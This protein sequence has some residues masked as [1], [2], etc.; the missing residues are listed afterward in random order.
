MTASPRD[1][2]VGPD[3]DISLVSSDMLFGV[4]MLGEVNDTV[5]DNPNPFVI[6]SQSLRLN[7]TKRNLLI[8]VLYGFEIHFMMG[9]L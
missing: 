1:D 4:M 5:D 2:P 8:C 3:V 9:M 6:D 7:L